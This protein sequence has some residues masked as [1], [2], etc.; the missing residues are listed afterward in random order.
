MYYGGKR[1]GRCR[2]LRFLLRQLTDMKIKT[3]E[4]GTRL[5]ENIEEEIWQG[6]DVS[7]CSS[8]ESL[9][10]LFLPLPGPHGIYQGFE[11]DGTKYCL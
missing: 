2:I 5:Q 8:S 10:C 4:T 6:N 7:E 3:G 11:Y 9:S 1:A